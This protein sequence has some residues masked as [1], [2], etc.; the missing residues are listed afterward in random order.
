[1]NR[2]AGINNAADLSGRRIGIPE[3][4][5]TAGVWARGMLMHEYGVDPRSIKWVTGGVRDPGR[6]PM[7]EL[8]I[9]GIE[10][11]HEEKRSLNDLL[12]AGEIDAMIAPQLPQA[13]QEGRPEVGLLFPD[14][15]AVEYEYCRKT[16]LFP[17][18]HVVVMRRALY[19][20]HPWA[21]VSLFKAFEQAKANCLPRLAVEEPPPVS[22]PWSYPL[23]QRFIALRG[24]DFW[25]YGVERN[26]PE[27]EALCQYTWEQGLVPARVDP[28][29][30]FLSNIAAVAG[31]RL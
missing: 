25:P 23:A 16:G 7:I 6:R 14:T 9:P 1:V 30:L 22:I 19:E 15:A 4:Q 27:I 29:E 3:Y 10:I 18:M 13:I 28:A 21:A 26:R 12:L 31:D 11:R 5:M 24:A 2:K 8:T 20:Q 17:I